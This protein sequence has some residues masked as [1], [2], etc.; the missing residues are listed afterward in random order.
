MKKGLQGV[1]QQRTITNGSK[2]ELQPERHW[3]W[4][5]QMYSGQWTGHTITSAGNVASYNLTASSL[6]GTSRQKCRSGKIPCQNYKPKRLQG[7]FGSTTLTSSKF[8]S[9]VLRKQRK[10]KIRSEREKNN[11]LFMETFDNAKDCLCDKQFFLW[12]FCCLF[13]RFHRIYLLTNIYILFVTPNNSREL[14]RD[15]EGTS[16][17][18]CR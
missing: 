10:R 6:R 2:W 7:S 18:R 5:Q 16:K 9:S 3:N 8:P 14:T 1:Q 4:F 11:C 13:T 17:F 12:S 15:F